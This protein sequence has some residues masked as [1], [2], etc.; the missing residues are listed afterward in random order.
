MFIVNKG[1]HTHS[2]T[3]EHGK[4]LLGQEDA[5]FR[6]AS[7]EEIEAWYKAQGLEVPKER[8]EPAKGKQD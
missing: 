5:G 3:E 1:G 8:S 4:A 2:V 6:R 7:A